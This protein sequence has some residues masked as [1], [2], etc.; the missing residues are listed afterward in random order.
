MGRPAR[1][2]REQLLETARRV[3]AAKGFDAATLG[4]LAEAG[5]DPR[6]EPAP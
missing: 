4:R 3:F 1:I 5:L 2:S 6:L